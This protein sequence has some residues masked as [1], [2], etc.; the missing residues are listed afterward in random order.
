[1]HS[2][3]VYNAYAEKDNANVIGI[4]KSIMSFIAVL[5]YP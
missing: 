2:T 4:E 5:E 1:M 3:K